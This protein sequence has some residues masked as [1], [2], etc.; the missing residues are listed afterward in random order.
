MSRTLFKKKGLLAGLLATAVAAGSFMVAPQA[1]ATPSSLYSLMQDGAWTS[2]S[3]GDAAAQSFTTGSVPVTLNS[4]RIWVRNASVNGQSSAPATYSLALYSSNNFG[5]A[6]LLST[7]TSGHNLSTWADGQVEHGASFQLSANTRYWVVMRSVSG[8]T[9]AWKYSNNTPATNVS[10]APTFVNKVEVAGGW[11]PGPA[12][13]GYN[14]TLTTSALTP[15]TTTAPPT[16]TPA[17]SATCPTRRP[18]RIY[19]TSMSK[20]IGAYLVARCGYRTEWRRVYRTMGAFAV[21]TEWAK[22]KVVPQRWWF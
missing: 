13:G 1:N 14:M 20:G 19:N 8:N 16:T 21:P 22:K 9:A 2:I 7:I 6:S 3:Q 5:P 4:V 17:P 15:P 10:P 11:T 12:A 18:Y